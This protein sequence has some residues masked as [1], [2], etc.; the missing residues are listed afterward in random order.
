MCRQEL[1]S[2][3][4]WHNTRARNGLVRSGDRWSH[5]GRSIE[6]TQ[7]LQSL[8]LDH[9]PRESEESKA[10]VEREEAAGAAAS[11]PVFCC[12]LVPPGVKFGLHVFEPRCE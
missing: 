5:G 11:I 8:L 1:A 9:Y 2:L 10:R 12:A 3:L 7:Q 6:V 4:V